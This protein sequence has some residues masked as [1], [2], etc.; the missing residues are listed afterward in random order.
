MVDSLINAEQKCSEEIDIS[1]LKT[2]AMQRLPQNLA[3]RQEILEEETKMTIDVFLARLSI[4]L[5]L[6]RIEVKP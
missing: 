1:G 5:R 2:F 4:W 3:L 6:L